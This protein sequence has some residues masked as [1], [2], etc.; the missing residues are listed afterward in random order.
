MKF[1][2][3]DRGNKIMFFWYITE[4]SLMTF[5]KNLLPQ[6]YTLFHIPEDRNFDTG[7]HLS[8]SKHHCLRM[9]VCCVEW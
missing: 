6:P 4:C 9:F 5:G 1:G 8:L 7:T 2:F 3:E